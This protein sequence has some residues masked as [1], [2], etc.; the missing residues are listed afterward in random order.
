MLLVSQWSPWCNNIVEKSTF[1]RREEKIEPQQYNNR[2]SHLEETTI[3]AMVSPNI[4]SSR[5]EPMITGRENKPPPPPLE[6][7]TDP[8][9]Q[10]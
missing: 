10:S 9:K 5:T 1:L 6:D 7:G 2:C 3:S 8:R 4:Q